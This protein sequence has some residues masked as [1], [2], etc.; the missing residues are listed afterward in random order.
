MK[1]F[2]VSISRVALV[3]FCFL[4]ALSS[5]GFA[6][7]LPGSAVQQ[8]TSKCPPNAKCLNFVGLDSVRTDV[9]ITN[10]ATAVLRKYKI[11]V[12]NNGTKLVWTAA[13][14]D[15][16]TG[17]IPAVDLTGRNSRKAIPQN[18][19]NRTVKIVAVGRDTVRVTFEEFDGDTGE[20]SI[21]FGKGNFPKA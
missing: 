15:P 12:V 2:V 8:I 7:T 18:D 11:K 10:G 21:A 19:L 13:K 5:F 6:K 3:L 17:E 14:P 16:K 9:Q 4:T 20:Y 1:S